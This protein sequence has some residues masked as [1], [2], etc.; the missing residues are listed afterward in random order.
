[1]PKIDA[2]K[3]HNVELFIDDRYENY[4]ELSKAGIPCLLKT[5]KHNVNYNVGSRRLD[6]IHDLDK[7]WS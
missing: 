7:I 3:S 1:M 6:S 4:V 5:R 2:C